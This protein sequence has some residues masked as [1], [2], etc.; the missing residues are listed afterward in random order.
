MKPLHKALVFLLLNHVPFTGMR[1]GLSLYALHLGAS[2]ALVGSMMA[3]FSLLPMLGSVPLGRLMDRSGMRAPLL[4][5]V[6]L[7]ALSVLLAALSHSYYPLF[8]VT[9]VVGGAYNTVLNAVQQLVGRYSSASDRVANYSTLS[10]CLALSLALVPMATGFLIDHI[11]FT[12]TF[13][14][15]C[16][17]PLPALVMLFLNRL[18]GLDPVR[19]PP[20]PAADTATATATTAAASSTLDLI[21]N[22]DLRQLYIFNILFT[23]AWDLFLFMTPLYG[24]E[25]KLSASKIG[26]VVGTFSVAMFLVRS[27]AKPIS[28]RLSSRQMLLV[29]ITGSGLGALGF[30]LVGSL[31]LLVLFAFA[32]GLGQGL[33]APTMNALLYD[34]SPPG[35]VAE[36]MGLRTSISKSCQVV[37]PLLGGS[38]TAL[39]GVAPV[40]WIIAA[41]QLT[42][43]WTARRQW[44]Q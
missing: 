25:L 23:V 10:V 31:P 39:L 30:G 32:M 40:Y 33:A 34:T 44:R 17:M 4:V 11:G 3:L 9:L 37:L 1:L 26:V 41:M 27:L 15:L 7:V 18:P 8:V 35:R 22:R 29:S 21:R 13:F 12:A 42:A 14:S 19:Q 43:G 38:V 5:A 16:V 24:A 36:A 28:R 2:P 6:T 20:S